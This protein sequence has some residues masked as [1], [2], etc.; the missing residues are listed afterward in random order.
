MAFSEHYSSWLR[1]S[2]QWALRWIIVRSA[3][4]AVI[5]PPPGSFF[6][7]IGVPAND[8]S[9]GGAISDRLA[10]RTVDFNN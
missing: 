3:G 10:D 6:R 7:L 2:S 1:F 5:V 8:R 4:R 9:F